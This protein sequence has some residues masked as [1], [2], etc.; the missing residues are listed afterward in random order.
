[1][2]S[3][4]LISIK[5]NLCLGFLLLFTLPCQRRQ[6][7]FI[8]G[9][10]CI[11]KAI[12][13][14]KRVNII[15]KDRGLHLNKT[16]SMCIII[17]SKKQKLEATKILNANPLKCGDISIKEVQVFKWLGQFIS[18]KGLAHSVLFT[19]DAREGKIRGACL[20]IASIIQEVSKYWRNGHSSPT[21]GI[22]LCPLTTPWG[23]NMGSDQ[24][25]SRGKTRRY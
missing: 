9:L 19:I 8:H 21:L 17:G 11:S 3:Q 13:A 12:R 20:E 7:D 14:R 16:K 1:M 22:L 5:I 25:S 15:I 6:D 2:F 10:D 4:P 23:G 24:F 18:S